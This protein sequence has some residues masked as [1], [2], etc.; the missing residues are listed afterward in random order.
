MADG[1]AVSPASQAPWLSPADPWG[2]PCYPAEAGWWTLPAPAKLNLFLRITGRRADGYHRLQTVFRLLDWGDSVHLRRDGVIAR[3]GESV[4]G[5][6]PEHD[7][8]VRAAQ[9]LRAAAG[10]GPGVEIAVSKRIPVGGGLGGGSSDAAT[11]LLGLD[12]LWGL[13]WT[14]SRLAALGLGLGADVPVFVHGSNAWAEGIG[15]V[16]TPLDLPPAAYLLFA[17]G[18]H[19]PT[20]ALFQAADLT[21]DSPPATMAD[22]ISGNVLD[23]AFEPVLRRREPAVEAA[24]QRLAPLGQVRLTGSGSVCF[25]EYASLD[26]AHAACAALVAG[27]PAAAGR[28][29]VAAG[30]PRSPLHAALARDGGGP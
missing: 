19:A 3:H 21:R 22:F 10:T 7:L 30:A 29:W 11:V 23:N 8:L 27:D 14:R 28:A 26:A 15:E 5:L 16:L 17:P 18:L 6:A 24:F 13:G 9:A 4:P 25:V 20:A 2:D 1:G 12:Q